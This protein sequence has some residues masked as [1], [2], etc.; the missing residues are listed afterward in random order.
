LERGQEGEKRKERTLRGGQK[1][2]IRSLY[3]VENA[4]KTPYEMV[5]RL[6]HNFTSILKD[7]KV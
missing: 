3:E 7:L 5:G 1:L 2:L 4:K 6:A